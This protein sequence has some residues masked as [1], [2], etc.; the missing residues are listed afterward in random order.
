MDGDG[1][2]SE[3]DLNG[4]IAGLIATKAGLRE[5]PSNREEEMVFRTTTESVIEIDDE[6]V[7]VDAVPGER[8]IE[9][10]INAVRN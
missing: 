2:V 3:A 4:Y 7:N 8:P 10:A 6:E 5:E 9:D 1:V